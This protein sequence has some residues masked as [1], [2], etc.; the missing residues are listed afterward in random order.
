M[1][2]RTKAEI[3]DGVQDVKDAKIVAN[4]TIKYHTTDGRTVYRLHLT[5]IVTIRMLETMREA[6]EDEQVKA[7]VPSQALD[8]LKQLQEWLRN[9]EAES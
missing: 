5:D 3:M 6:A 9:W 8:T 7:M 1:A 2:R 4:N